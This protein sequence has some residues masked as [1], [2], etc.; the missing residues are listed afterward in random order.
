MKPL[1]PGRGS[2]ISFSASELSD[3]ALKMFQ[4]NKNQ[5]QSNIIQMIYLYRVN[6][7]SNIDSYPRDFK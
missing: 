5:Y 4:N 6:K 7:Q 1:S 2:D 3:P